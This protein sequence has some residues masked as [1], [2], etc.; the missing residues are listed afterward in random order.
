MWVGG[1]RFRIM[2]V[3]VCV[4]VCGCGCGWLC[5]RACIGALHPCTT[6]VKFMGALQA[7]PTYVRARDSDHRPGTR[8]CV[9]EEI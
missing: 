3:W 4:G 8:V 9:L 5:M 2:Y 6:C 7:C 1:R